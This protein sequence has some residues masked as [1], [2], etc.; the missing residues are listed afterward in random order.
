MLDLL[1]AERQLFFWM[2]EPTTDKDEE[3]ADVV[4]RLI[5]GSSPL[6]QSESD[7][8]PPVGYDMFGGVAEE[9]K[10][11]PIELDTLKEIL[12]SIQSSSRPS[13]AGQTSVQSEPP[14]SKPSSEQ[15][16]PE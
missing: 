9:P 7:R 11:S 8:I 5:N 2:Q 10:Q 15:P 4:N 16:K 12:T 14:N 1:V 6:A 13:S 3:Y